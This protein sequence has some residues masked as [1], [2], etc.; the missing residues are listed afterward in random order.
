MAL[1]ERRV[2]DAE[3][4]ADPPA[5]PVRRIPFVCGALIAACAG[6][7]LAE[8][9]GYLPGRSEDALQWGALYGPLV[10]QGQ[11]WRTVGHVFEH[12]GPLHLVLNMSVVVTLGFT[13]ERAIGSPRFA[14]VCLHVGAGRQDDDFGHGRS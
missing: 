6:V 10:S 9:A 5:E 14:V 13:L 2:L 12:G 8:L 7:Y 3:P 11:W 1:S 4:D